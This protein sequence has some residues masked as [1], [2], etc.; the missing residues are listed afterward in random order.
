[1]T[2]ENESQFPYSHYYHLHRSDSSPTAL[3][4][5][6]HKYKK[7][8]VNGYMNATVG[9]GQGIQMAAGGEAG[10]NHGVGFN[11][12]GHLGFNG[13]EMHGSGHLGGPSY[14][15]N[16][17]GKTYLDGTQ[18][19]GFNTEAQAGG[20]YGLEA[21]AKTQLGGGQ[22]ASFET[23]AKLGGESGLAANAEG[24]LGLSQGGG[25]SAGLQIGGEQGLGMQASGQLGG[26][27]GAGMGITGHVG[28]YNSK[29][30][31]NIGGKDKESKD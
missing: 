9:N 10:G 28:N 25:L 23:G 17:Q 11:A 8:I 18:G 1:M 24:H 27:Q 5:A 13:A 26:G 12:G 21:Q 31:F 3:P 6:Q 29:V 4:S 30:G 14:G 2:L 20:K 16:A 7:Q 22:G 15:I 19:L